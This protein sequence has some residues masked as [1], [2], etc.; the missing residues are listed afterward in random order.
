MTLTDSAVKKLSPIVVALAFIVEPMLFAGIFIWIESGK[1]PQE[2][3]WSIIP[4][5]A[6]GTTSILCQA[7]V[8]FITVSYE[9]TPKVKFLLYSMWL[10]VFFSLCT[11]IPLYFIGSQLDKSLPETLNW[12]HD[13]GWIGTTTVLINLCVAIVVQVG[14]SALLI[15]IRLTEGKKTIVEGADSEM[16]TLPPPI[17]LKGD[18][19]TVIAALVQYGDRGM[20]SNE[21][22]GET[23]L[24]SSVCIDVVEE[25]SE[26]GLVTRTEQGRFTV[27]KDEELRLKYGIPIRK[28]D[29]T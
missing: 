3:F 25:L 10:S 9:A 28:S 15:A 2:W 7:L 22:S 5:W 23:G 26:K 17:P 14:P 18:S 11:V 6:L 29:W 27:T 1:P 8:L 4:G 13:E 12:I 16:P 19:K 24:S 20:V 21:V